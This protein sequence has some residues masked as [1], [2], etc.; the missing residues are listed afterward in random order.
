MRFLSYLPAWDWLKDYDKKLFADDS[1][2][3]L[4]VTIM[5]IP[6][7]L[8]YALL[9]G[10]PAQVG[11]YAS[12]FPLLGYALFGSSRVLAVGPVAVVSLLTASSIGA[13]AEAGSIAYIEAALALALLSGIFMLLLGLLRAGFVAN[14]LSHSVISGFITASGIL[15]A[16]SQL[17]HLLGISAHGHSLPELLSSLFAGL[18][19]FSLW[20]LL[21]GVAATAFLFW[22]RSSLKALLLRRGFS[23]ALADIVSKAG[24]VAAIVVSIL[25]VRVLSLDEQGVSIVGEIPQG[26]PPVTVPPFNWELWK[27]LLP[28]AIVISI[29]GFVES[30]SVAQTLA[31]KRRQSIDPN[32]ELLGLGAAN[33]ASAMG[34]G[35]PVTGGFA[36]SV[37][38]FDAGARTPM[39]GVLTAAGILLATLLL[40]PLFFYLPKA[41]LAATIIVAVVSLIDIDAIKHTWRYSKTDFAAMFAT[42]MVVLLL[43]VEA[44]VIVGVSVSILVLLW[45]TSRPHIAVVG[46][47]GDT[48][49]FRNYLRHDVKML[50]TAIMM[51][52]DERLYF[53]NS[54]NLEQRLL[55][56]ASEHPKLKDVVLVCTAVND[57]DSSAVETL[58]RINELLET[59][60]VTFHLAEVKG[61]VMD[62]LQRSHLLHALTGQVHLSQYA[63]FK[64]LQQAEV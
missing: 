56:M 62:K 55:K 17:K 31:A 10:L 40:T 29:I 25:L 15:I 63:V 3:A 2:A 37:V 60:G 24:P 18:D 32:R 20:T 53:A 22:V 26:I 16:T 6:Q 14:F 57:I 11:L 34:G 8:A 4:I 64:Q 51:R 9:A 58:E 44:G 38:N 61:P 50:E 52:I 41:V 48:E 5:L 33:I 13:I 47:V 59:M 12:I 36:R 7:S 49:H 45:Q 1:M 54:R 30:V 42:I 19:Q 27:A 28:A 43:G 23:S 46:Q 35:Y 21:I 39:A